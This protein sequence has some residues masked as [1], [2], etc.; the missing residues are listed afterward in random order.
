MLQIIAYNHIINN[1]FKF[2]IHI[3]GQSSELFRLVI[4]AKKV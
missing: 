1:I 4:T 3:I 2:I